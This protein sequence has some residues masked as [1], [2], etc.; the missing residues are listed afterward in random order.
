MAIEAP[1]PLKSKFVWNGRKYDLVSYRGD[2][3]D[4]Y[5][6]LH[7][8]EHR[9]ENPDRDDPQTMLEWFRNESNAGDNYVNGYI[10][11]KD[12]RV[13]FLMKP[14]TKTP[15]GF[16][17][18]SASKR[19]GSSLGSLYVRKSERKKGLAIGM[20]AKALHIARRQGAEK[21]LIP[22]LTDKS[23][24]SVL[25][26]FKRPGMDSVMQGA[27]MRTNELKGPDFIVKLIKRLSRK[28]KRNK[29]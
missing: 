20:V 8:K 10:H 2:H 19:F 25:Q 16:F 13:F 22:Q 29:I 28:E 14:G 5:K 9:W 24:N 4:A 1:R 23:M 18:V 17:S 27:E 26:A 12:A 3:K 6:L 21:V 7:S 11:S 15:L